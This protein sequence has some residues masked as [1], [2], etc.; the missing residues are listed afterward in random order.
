MNK[1]K[2]ILR[3]YNV[4]V[5]ALL[6]LGIAY[7]CSRFVHL[8]NTEFTDNAMVHRN[9]IP[10]NTRVLGFIKEIR[11][12]EFQHV[13]KG[14]TLVIIDDAEY[15]LALARAEADLKGQRSGSSAVTASIGTTQRNVSVASAGVQVASAGIAEAKEDMDNARRD[16]ER[17]SALLAKEA[18]TQQ[19]FDNA[20]TRYEQA[21]SRWEAASARMQQA[22]ASR[23]ATESVTGEQTH[24]LGQSRAGESVAEAQLNLA[25]LNLSYTVITAPCD[26]YVGRKNIY[27]G[28][29]VQPGQLMVNVVDDS[30]VWVIA[31]YRESQ[32]HH[33]HTGATVTFK[34]DAVPGVTYRGR[35]SA[36]S[37]AS[38]AA[39]DN[40]PVD[41]ATGNFV[42][43]EQRVPVRIEL[44]RDNKEADVARLLGGLNAETKVEY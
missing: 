28:Q 7:V 13:K 34:C 27:T 17:F 37:E 1:K 41:N 22:S 21:R 43:V 24:R 16:Y 11:F 42:K 15:R 23:K 14:N 29:L 32:L 8:G 10:V 19:Q 12:T 5:V 38:G 26:G 31:N 9:Q 18:V 39:I 2:Q 40:V 36:I 4:V 44:T 6:I 3:A 35:V 33:I 25:R 20:K 30:S